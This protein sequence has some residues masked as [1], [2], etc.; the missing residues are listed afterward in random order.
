[1][2]TNSPEALL[3]ETSTKLPQSHFSAVDYAILGSVLVASVLVG[4]FASWRKPSSSTKGFLVGGRDL[5]P[6]AVCLSLLGGVISSISIQG[7][8]T[9]VYLHGTQLWMNLLG[10]T[11][12][13]LIVMFIFVPVF[14][15]LNIASLCQYLELRFKSSLM[16]KLASLT[17][18]M[19]NIMYLG[20]CLYAPSLTL[21]SALGIPTYVAILVS[22]IVCAIYVTWG[23]IR[24]VIYADI[25]Q[26]IMMFLGVFIVIVQV[27]AE[28]GGVSEVWDIA[29]RGG[30]LEFFNF[31]IDPL[32]RHT[33]WSVQ[34]LG[35]Y[36]VV[37]VVGFSQTQYQRLT[38]VSTMQKAQWLC[39]F[40]RISMSILWSLFYFAGLV[41]YAIYAD[42]D[43]VSS[44]KVE[45]ADQILAYMVGDKLSHIPG[46]MGL[47]VSA[48]AG[49][50]LS[51]LSSF[52]NSTVVL[53][54]EDIFTG[55]ETFNKMPQRTNMLISRALCCII[56]ILAVG[57]AVFVERLGTLFQAGYTISSAL[58]SPFDGLFITA[59]AAP[60][61]NVKGVISGFLAAMT[62]NIW[63]G[64]S[65]MTYGTGTTEPLPLSTDACYPEVDLTLHSNWDTLVVTSASNSSLESSLQT[66]SS[67]NPYPSIYDLSYC[68]IG[69]IGISI[70]YMV[71]TIVSIITG[72]VKPSEVD[73]HLV[74][75]TCFRAY[76]WM[77]KR[78]SPARSE[79]PRTQT[80]LKTAVQTPSGDSLR[81]S[82]DQQKDS[83]T[84]TQSNSANSPY[85]I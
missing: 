79:L 28:L 41:A 16:K 70:V 52:V 5:N 53:L 75:Q 30:R 43:P 74:N 13:T 12:G 54:W 80:S 9:E 64:L 6:V 11:W 2:N 72:A 39:V 58:T 49:A 68:Y 18:V 66:P 46:M 85:P 61:V 20:V 22:G 84:R 26:T 47:F 45:K 14:Y 69:L 62:F 27:V 50:L 37:S 4:A 36:F 21:G 77:Y 57:S 71:S 31:N 51:S 56:V 38:S 35:L 29:K 55:W 78:L 25:I 44:G 63:L 17:Q 76:S 23:G 3:E 42:C 34:S 8:S 81:I 1:M 19:N 24:G 59:V 10:C 48:V 33:F 60:W 83:V 7:N 67:G 65:Q 73:Q 15:P 32:E 82:E 40:F